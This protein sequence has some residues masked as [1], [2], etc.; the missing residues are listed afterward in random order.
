VSAA[1][2]AGFEAAPSPLA[3]DLAAAARLG[4]CAEGGITRPAWSAALEQTIALVGARLEKLGLETSRDGA[5]NFFARWGAPGGGGA[6]M[7]GSHL[8]TVPRGGHLDGALGVIAAVEAVRILREDG[9][10]PARP[11]V[12][13]SFMDEEGA[14]FGTA[15]FG[16]RA[17][18][19]EDLS[20]ALERRDADGIS[21]AEA[22]AARGFDPAGV[23]GARAVGELDAYLELHIEQGP[24]LSGRGLR[25]GVVDAICGVLGYRAVFRGE[26]NHAGTTPMDAR[27]DALIGAAR[28]ALA[29][30]DGAAGDP[31]LRATVGALEV[32]PGARNV[33][34]GR[35]ELAID[36]RCAD[37]ARVAEAERWVAELVAE[38]GAAEGLEVEFSPA[39]ALAPTAMAPR[40]VAA[41]EEAARGEGVEPL[42]MPSGA[43]HDAM[44]IGRHCD[45]GMLFVPSRGGISHSPREWTDP[46]D[47]AL[48]ARV[49]A[50]SLRRLA[51]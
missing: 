6:V 27:R 22:M 30:R 19:G 12:V 35:C 5:G 3:A 10:R 50:E 33:I 8:D 47:C 1:T 46:A 41:I 15:L 44:V 16:S 49:L 26:A 23:A 40:V 42:R 38:I 13:A 43:G 14:R 20:E 45:A 11:I 28:V 29:L 31:A 7:A 37:P 4:A 21:V 51:A 25:L 9:F 34:P 18:C 36:V 17:F 2:A 32:A 24:V 48:G 39:Y